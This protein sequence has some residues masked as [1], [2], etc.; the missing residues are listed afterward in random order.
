M[1]QYL[2]HD[3]IQ[4]CIIEDRKTHYVMQYLTIAE[5]HCTVYGLR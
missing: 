3:L 4:C 5:M 2:S 1:S